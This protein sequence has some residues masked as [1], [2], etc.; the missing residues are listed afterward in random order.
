MRR[1]LLV[2][3]DVG[4][5][6]EVNEAAL[7]ALRVGTLSGV[8]LL[9]DGVAYRDAIQRLGCAPPC[10]SG[11][12]IS[13]TRPE[14]ALMTLLASWMSRGVRIGALESD[15]RRQIET[16]LESGLPLHHVNGHQ[17]LHVL[18]VIFER[19][20]N[21]C[22]E[23][24]IPYVRMPDEPIW[25]RRP[26]SAVALRLLSMRARHRLRAA[27]LHSADHFRGFHASGQLDGPTLRRLLRDLPPGTSEVL[28]HPAIAG[29]GLKRVEHWHYRWA[30]EHE[31]LG[32]AL[33]GWMHDAGVHLARSYECGTSSP[34]RTCR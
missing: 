24:R 27:G 3:D 5:C 28:C 19:L 31:A 33:A 20:L 22:A 17:H 10:W 25:G 2:A 9:V 6:E 21:L 32:E 30:A 8:S 11:L 29:P 26:L 16:Y 18:P 13:L 14:D 12:H 23:Y 34:A 7:R 4:L 1:V 15:M